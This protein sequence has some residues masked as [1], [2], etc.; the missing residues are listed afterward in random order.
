MSKI[1]ARLVVLISG[2]LRPDER[3]A[4]LGDL[5]ESQ[6]GPAQALVSL[7]GLIIRQQ[8]ALWV[9]WRP[10]LALVGVVAI[11]G[12]R[13]LSMAWAV[14]TPVFI[15]LQIFWKYGSF[16][17]SGLT[18][19][20][21]IIT[22]LSQTLGLVFWSWTSGFVMGALARRTIW[23]SGT[24]FLAI[25]SYPLTLKWMLLLILHRGAKHGTP[26]L[27]VAIVMMM[28]QAAL[29]FLFFLLPFAF[30]VR[31]GLRKL[32]LSIPQAWGLTALMILMTAL[33]VWT[34]GWSGAAVTRWATGAWNPSIGWQSRLLPLTVLSWPVAYLFVTALVSQSRPN[35][36]PKR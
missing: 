9:D 29:Q 30:G 2:L 21:E 35:P 18:P 6:E 19:S 36:I 20:E 15:D 33:S 34:G 27:S 1:L 28:S 13:L 16:Y 5:A 31:A 10:W 24:I 17:S 14:S 8:A 4:V 12:P 7:L 3:D 22:F 11:I 23:I 32:A 25:W 26:D